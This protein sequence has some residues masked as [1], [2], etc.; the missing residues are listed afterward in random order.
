MD[1]FLMFMVLVLCDNAEDYSNES[2]DD[3]AITNVLIKALA[4]DSSFLDDAKTV[5]TGMMDKGMQP[6]A[7]TYTPVFKAFAGWRRD[8]VKKG[9]EFLMEMKTRGLYG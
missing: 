9:K 1:M 5:L 8:N 2:D 3:D 7:R 6:N 4:K